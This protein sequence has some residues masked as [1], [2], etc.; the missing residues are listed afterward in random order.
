M[1]PTIYPNKIDLLIEDIGISKIKRQSTNYEIIHNKINFEISAYVFESKHGTQ[2]SLELINVPINK[3]HELYKLIDCKYYVNISFTLTD[4]IN[5]SNNHITNSEY[6]K[7][8][9]L[10]EVYEIF[11]K[12]ASILNEHIINHP[13]DLIFTI[14]KNIDNKIKNI[15]LLMYKNLFYDKFSLYDINNETFFIKNKL[16]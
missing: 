2:Y 4:R 3:N 9:N 10:F 1:R 7:K 11:G 16:F 12:I 13:N 6:I 5:K 14:N 8:T 15:S